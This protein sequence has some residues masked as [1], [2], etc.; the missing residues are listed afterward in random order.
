MLTQW[1]GL[2][3]GSRPPGGSCFPAAK[4][5]AGRRLRAVSPPHTVLFA[6]HRFGGG[7]GDFWLGIGFERLE[8]RRCYVLRRAQVVGQRQALGGS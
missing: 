1:G 6:G 7:F 3:A 2:S 8:Q 4:E 5:P